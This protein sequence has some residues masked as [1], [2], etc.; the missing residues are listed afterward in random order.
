MS[1]FARSL[2]SFRYR[3]AE[4]EAWQPRLPISAERE[5]FIAC[6]PGTM[7]AFVLAQT[8]AAEGV[9]ICSAH[10]YRGPAEL[11]R[12]IAKVARSEL[13]AAA[14]V[15]LVEEPLNVQGGDP[16]ARLARMGGALNLAS[17][18]GMVA[19]ALSIATGAPIGWVPPASWQTVLGPD[20]AGA[21]KAR[22]VELVESRWPGMLR[23][24]STRK[25]SR[26][27]LADA[28]GMAVWYARWRAPWAPWDAL[29]GALP[30]WTTTR[31]ASKPRKAGATRRKGRY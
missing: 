6:D 30:W 8:D 27:G 5:V 13:G 29:F 20:R 2:E 3:R 25:P 9:A 12:W 1:G 10:V 16:E 15:V 19:G 31:K 22:S 28:V 18:A 4:L 24:L 11:A 14:S 17:S 21:T 7:G 26:E 23:R